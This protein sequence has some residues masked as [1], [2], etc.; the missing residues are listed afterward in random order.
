MT[1]SSMTQRLTED[2]AI[3]RQW[4][5]GGR[6]VPYPEID[7]INVVVGDGVNAMTPGIAT[8]IRVDFN[9][10]ITGCFLQE[11]DGNSG[12]VSIDIQRAPGGASPAF[13]SITGVANPAIVG[14]R[15]FA[16]ETLDGWT[17]GI[18]RRDYLR[19]VVTSAA[20]IRRVHV[21]LR[22]RRLEP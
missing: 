14:G 8:A 7:T 5:Q 19:Y 13:V 20:T 12:S 18:N 2:L 9:A 22:I 3:I 10:R 6:V 1:Q 4:S 21:G 11:F 15:Y 17:T 16:D